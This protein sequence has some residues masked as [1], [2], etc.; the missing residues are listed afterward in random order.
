M[1]LTFCSVLQF[2]RQASLCVGCGRLVNMSVARGIQS[3]SGGIAPRDLGAK[4]TPFAASRVA[5]NHA[6]PTSLSPHAIH[7]LFRLTRCR[8]WSTCASI[9]QLFVNRVY[10]DCAQRGQGVHRSRLLIIL[11]I[12][13]RN[14]FDRR[15]RCSVVLDE[16]L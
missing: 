9:H 15:V 10:R 7:C 6:F 16:S 1:C 12:V 13:L 5:S 14:T 8:N 3:R 4:G 11:K 2:C